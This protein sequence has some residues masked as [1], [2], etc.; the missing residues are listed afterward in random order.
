MAEEREVIARLKVQKEGDT[1]AF[2]EVAAELEGLEA[3]AASASEAVGA[4]FEKL[5]SGAG[6]GSADDLDKIQAS[7]EKVVVAAEKFAAAKGPEAQTAS[8]RELEAAWTSFGEEFSEQIEQNSELAKSFADGLEQIRQKGADLADPITSG[9]REVKEELEALDA[10]GE[11]GFRG[12]ENGAAKARTSINELKS[13]IA[14]AEEEGRDVGDGARESLAQLEGQLEKTSR[15]AAEFRNTQEDVKDEMKSMRSETDLGRGSIND[16]GDIFERMSPKIS[17][18]IGTAAGIAGALYAGYEAGTKLREGLNW[19]TDGGFDEGVQGLISN[20]LG[21]EESFDSNADAAQRL[22]NN[23]RILKANG[24]DPVGLSAAEV[25]KK[26]AALTKAKNDSRQAAEDLSK[27]EEKWAESLDLS[28]KSLDES[29]KK[30]A[31]YIADFAKQNQQ[32]SQTDLAKIF[33]PMIQGVLDSYAR[34]GKEAPAEVAKLAS[35]WGV[36][37]SAAQKAAN[38]QKKIVDEMVADITGAADG[39]KA[40]LQAQLATLSAVFSKIDFGNLG[41][42]QIEKAKTFLQQYVDTSRKAGEQIPED[43][44]DQA[45]SMGILVAQMEITSKG[46]SGLSTEQGK[47]AGSA[48]A[49]ATA[50]D[51]ASR[52][53]KTLEGE[54]KASSVEFDKS[55]GVMKTV[56]T[57][58]GK[59]TV[60]YDEATGTLRTIKGAHTELGAAAKTAGTDV[61]EGATKAGEGK[62]ALEEAG[63]AAGAAGT[64]LDAAKKGAEGLGAAGDAAKTAATNIKAPLADVGTAAG[65]A[66]TALGTIEST[67][68]RLNALNLSGLITALKAVETQALATKLAIDSI[69]DDGPN[70]GGGGGGGF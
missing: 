33:G 19:L 66:A 37:T 26:V 67:I 47:V 45:A 42:D 6:G 22:Q 64:G 10:S 50:F 30:L 34:L 41:A 24:I 15:K 21:L 56:A 57:E 65:S 70:S 52:S 18:F 4:F 43:I 29:S 20:V 55:T 36:L 31:T 32:L 53:L 54:V 58:V 8:V 39:L 9:L 1:G 40:S 5:K 60:E 13:A 7:L 63:K 46:A 49:G 51:A 38:D 69:D 35:G 11:N 14:S 12:F 27:A 2:K 25:E 17:K 59:T 44:A 23:M 16:L 48:Q 61:K 62:Q 68:A 3:P 28:G